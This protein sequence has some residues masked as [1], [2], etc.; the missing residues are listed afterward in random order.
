MSSY[1]GLSSFLTGANETYIAE[2]Y[3]RD[4]RNPNSVDTEWVA[5]FSDLKD[6]PPEIGGELRGASW[7]PR[8][9]QVIGANGRH[10]GLPDATVGDA[11]P[12]PDAQTY[13][14]AASVA[15]NKHPAEYPQRH[16]H[17]SS[18]EAAGCEGSESPR[19]RSTRAG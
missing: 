9:G 19:P 6:G 11:A 13:H 14:P 4:L 2:L 8:T 16:E 7:A 12:P 10:P 15:Q 5:L 1:T 17:P 3:E 18:H